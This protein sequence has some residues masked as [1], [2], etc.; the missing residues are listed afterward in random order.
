MKNWI[1]LE[2]ILI[3]FILL[4]ILANCYLLWRNLNP[5]INPNSRLSNISP[6]FKELMRSVY[7]EPFKHDHPLWIE[8][9][10]LK[11]FTGRRLVVVIDRCTNCVI[12]SLK[13]WEEIIKAAGLPPTILVTKD[14]IEEVKKVL[15]QMEIKAEIISDPK[16]R[17]SQ[18]LNA[19]FLPRVYAFEN[20][21]LVWKQ[22]RIDIE[23]ALAEV[24]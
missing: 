16:G 12:R 21:R 4:L 1:D 2:R 18:R 14:P 5:N 19:F 20:G 8:I 11:G 6:W 23:G 24:K 7:Q 9:E 22:G 10:N 13:V 15:H 3:T 17:L